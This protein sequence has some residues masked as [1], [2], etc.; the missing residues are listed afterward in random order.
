MF[1]F[2]LESMRPRVTQKLNSNT[3]TVISV[4]HQLYT[5]Y[6]NIYPN[7]SSI[8]NSLTD[9]DEER[10]RQMKRSGMETRPPRSRCRCRVGG[11]AS[12]EADSASSLCRSRCA[13]HGL[14]DIGHIFI[15]GLGSDKKFTNIRN[16]RSGYQ[17]SD[18]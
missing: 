12:R 8:K 9:V 14:R 17:P 2:E 1:F 16:M 3:K 10:G 15:E 18:V 6:S 11:I 4:S 7:R 5:I 13:A